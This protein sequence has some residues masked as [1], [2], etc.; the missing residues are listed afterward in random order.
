MHTV[1]SRKASQPPVACT[2]K[3][4]APRSS[5][6]DLALVARAAPSFPADLVVPPRRG[7]VITTTAWPVITLTAV[8][9]PGDAL[10]MASAPAPAL[11]KAAPLCG[12]RTKRQTR[13]SARKTPQSPK[14]LHTCVLALPPTPE[15]LAEPDPTPAIE[16]V[17][18]PPDDDWLDPVAPLPRAR[19]LVPARRQGLV[20]VVAYILRDSGRRL[21]RWS[22]SRHKLREDRAELAR[23]TREHRSFQLQMEALTALREFARAE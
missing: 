15:P 12:K 16:P 3:I 14:I 5:R 6:H 10:V 18:L 7:A 21:A 20:D 2:S 9:V 17:V 19:S 8:D 23:A 4:P 1:R 11:R 13:K 22:A